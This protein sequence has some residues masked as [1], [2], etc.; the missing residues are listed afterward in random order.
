MSIEVKGLKQLI[1]KLRSL[2]DEGEARFK[3]VTK[4][5]ANNIATDAKQLAPYNFGK[6]R[7]G[8]TSYDSSGGKE[9]QFTIVARERYSPYLEFGTGGKVDL[10]YLTEAG[11]P[12]SE[13]LQFK[14]AG[15]KQVNILPQP[16]LYPAYIIGKQQYYEDL[17]N[18][19]KD[20]VSG[21]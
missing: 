18:E 9:I 2:G 16:F 4:E 10:S 14:G 11:F 19:I 13:A 1:K 20:L 21:V 3:Q 8:I 5:A 7:Q 17:R 15:I 6:L 12:A